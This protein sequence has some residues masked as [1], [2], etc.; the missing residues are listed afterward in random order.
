MADGQQETR[1]RLREK[2]G[3]SSKSGMQVICRTFQSE[4]SSVLF[5]LHHR[6]SDTTGRTAVMGALLVR[7]GQLVIRLRKQSASSI[8]GTVMSSGPLWLI[9]HGK[10]TAPSVF[11]SDGCHG[12]SYQR[13]YRISQ[14]FCSR[15]SFRPSNCT[16]IVRVALARRYWIVKTRMRQHY[17]SQI[18]PFSSYASSVGTSFCHSSTERRRTTPVIQGLSL[19]PIF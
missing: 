11:Q 15:N 1:R 7:I 16:S 14:H 18:S 9:L 12:E 4:Y 13:R 10:A 2:W 5:P 6:T 8:A 3:S 19:L 17:G